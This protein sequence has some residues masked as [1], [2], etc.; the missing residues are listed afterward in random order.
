MGGGGLSFLNKKTWHPARL[1]N[2]V[3]LLQ[4]QK[5]SKGSR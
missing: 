5:S 2:Q 1:D 4:L 3:E